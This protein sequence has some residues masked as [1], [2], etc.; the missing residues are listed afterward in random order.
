[1][2]LCL[3]TENQ[4]YSKVTPSIHMQLTFTHVEGLTDPVGNALLANFGSLS[5]PVKLHHCTKACL[6]VTMRGI[7]CT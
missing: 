1:M 2:M 3:K 5:H 6:I 7:G 4:S